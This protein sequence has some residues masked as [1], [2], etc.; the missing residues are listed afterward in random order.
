M[1]RA[2]LR[3]AKVYPS[4]KRASI[5][6]EI[7]DAYRE[8]RAVTDEKQLSLLQEEAEAALRLMNRFTGLK[9]TDTITYSM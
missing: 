1:Y 2:L 6:A 4:V 3:I 5:Q 9:Q 8:N 7:K